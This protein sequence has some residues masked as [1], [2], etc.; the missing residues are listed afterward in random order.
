VQEVI[1]R[2]DL[3]SL[4]GREAGRCKLTGSELLSKA[5]VVSAREAAIRLIISNSA[6]SFNLRRFTEVCAYCISCK[7]AVNID[8][9]LDWLIKHTKKPA[10]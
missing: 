10:A 5:P 3:R 8:I 7:N 2:L 6:F 9:C 4:T 1:E